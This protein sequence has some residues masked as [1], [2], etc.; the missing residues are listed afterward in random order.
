MPG[1]AIATGMADFVGPIAQLTARI[2]EAMHSKDIIRRLN[3][4][5]AEG[6]LHQVLTLLRTRTGHNFLS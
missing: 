3:T 5:Q 1:S 4:E 2:A 6:E